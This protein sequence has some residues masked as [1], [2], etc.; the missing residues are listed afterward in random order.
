MF[1]TRMRADCSRF[2]ERSS[3]ISRRAVIERAVSFFWAL[4]RRGIKRRSV[5]FS[6]TW[7]VESDEG[8]K[9]LEWD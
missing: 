5:D 1:S 3:A 7:E 6:F 4:R 9:A 8:G 2:E